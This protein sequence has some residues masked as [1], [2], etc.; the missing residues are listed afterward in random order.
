MNKTLL[1]DVPMC[2]YMWCSVSVCTYMY[3]H[4]YT[5]THQKHLHHHLP[6]E[7]VAMGPPHTACTYACVVVAWCEA[8]Y[9]ERF[10]FMFIHCHQVTFSSLARILFP[11]Q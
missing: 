4:M 6:R 11:K 5:H 10:S 2:V 7:K 1:V 3:I 9:H 8:V